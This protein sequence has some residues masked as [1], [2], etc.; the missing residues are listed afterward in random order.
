MRW[1]KGGGTYPFRIISQQNEGF[2]SACVIL[3]I[4]ADDCFYV[5][6]ELALSKRRFPD[7]ILHSCEFNLHQAKTQFSLSKIAIVGGGLTAATLAKNLIDVGIQV[8]LLARQPLKTQQ[9][10]FEPSWLGP[11]ALREFSNEPD[12][13]KRWEIIQRVRGKGNVTPEIVE[14]LTKSEAKGGLSLHTGVKILQID[15]QRQLRITTTE[16]TINDVDLVILA[17]GY[18]FNLERYKFLSHLIKQQNIPTLRGL[19]KLDESLQLLPVENLFGT[20]V[21]AQLQLGPVAG[22]IAGAALAYDRLREKI[23]CAIPTS[24]RR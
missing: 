24:H 15:G 7:S 12:W 18:R 13:E 6:S 9:F 14:A 1:E 17:T 3:A 19:P 5:P 2:R 22:N 23:L 16:S 21:V 8:I 11:K 4:G 20:G 10:D